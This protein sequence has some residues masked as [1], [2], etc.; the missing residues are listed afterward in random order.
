MTKMT[1]KS[2]VVYKVKSITINI[3]MIF[4]IEVE[5][6]PKYK[7]NYKISEQSKDFRSERTK[8]KASYY[9]IIKYII[10]LL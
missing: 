9:L 7:W 2:K 3:P 5:N 1:I 4:F 6:N 8:H 10:K